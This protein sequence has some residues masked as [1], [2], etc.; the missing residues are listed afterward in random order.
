MKNKFSVAY[1]GLVALV[2]VIPL[3]WWYYSVG[4]IVTIS[5]SP[6]QV[7]ILF[8]GTRLFLSD[9]ITFFLTA[10]RIY[11][12]IISLGYMVQVSR[13][14]KKVYSTMFWFPVFYILDPVLIYV[15]FNFIPQLLGI[16]IQYPFF[17][18][19]TEKLSS[20]YKGNMITAYVQSYPTFTYWI[21]LASAFLYP[22]S[23]LELRKAATK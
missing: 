18:W 10:F 13:G 21:A 15:L 20:S 5:D 6:F 8:L 9:V 19:G 17:I 3:P 4:G 2:T 11:V 22:L 14:Y 23:R 12:F 1:Y 7:L 16:P